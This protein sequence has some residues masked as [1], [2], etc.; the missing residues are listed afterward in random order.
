MCPAFCLEQEILIFI[1][2]SF[3]YHFL[4]NI[5]ESQRRGSMYHILICDD[6]QDGHPGPAKPNE[7][8]WG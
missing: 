7:V 3:L 8:G 2:S 5:I 1:K 4:L 6:E